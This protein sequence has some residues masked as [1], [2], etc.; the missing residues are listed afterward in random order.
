MIASLARHQNALY[1]SQWN[2]GEEPEQG[3][4]LAKGVAEMEY[5]DA[6]NLV[7]AIFEI[8]APSI[9]NAESGA[10]ETPLNSSRPFA[11][12]VVNI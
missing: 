4:F 8:V 1:L 10:P 12:V 7:E 11:H 3:P 6:L 2:F 5:E 9:R